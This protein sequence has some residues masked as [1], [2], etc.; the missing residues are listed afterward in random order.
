MSL[1]LGEKLRQ[2]REDRGF[3]LSEVAEQTRIS[4]LYLESIE[5]DDYRILPGGIFNKGFVKSYA[6]LVGLNEQEALSDYAEITGRTAAT[7]EEELKV[8]RPEVLTDD[9]AGSSMTPTIIFAVVIL[10]AMTAGV[11]FLVNYIRQP[12]EP[13]AT[14]TASKTNTNAGTDAAPEPSPTQSN[15]SEMATLKVEFKATTGPVALRATVDGEKAD[16]S[17][18]AGSSKTFE[19]KDSITLNYNRWNAGIVELL[20]NGKVIALPSAPLAPADRDRI[21]FTISK[22]NLTQILADGRISD[23]VPPATADANV[24]TPAPAGPTPGPTVQTPV[25][26]TPGPKA[27]PAANSSAPPVRPPETRTTPR[28][29]PTAAKPASNG[30]ND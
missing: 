8:Y 29:G 5:N 13:L 12:V 26:P 27:S 19:P 21:I 17:V 11:L 23:A 4:S 22:D 24:A 14:N 1:T 3:T 25:R 9:R 2:A 6:K 20:L 15:A 10:A 18:S 16:G 30:T 28:P 7:D